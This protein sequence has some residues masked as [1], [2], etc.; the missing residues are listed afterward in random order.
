MIKNNVNPT[1]TIPG[2]H[3]IFLPYYK[4][5]SKV[6]KSKKTPI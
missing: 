4:A 3:K 2:T 1:K 6:Y 5:A